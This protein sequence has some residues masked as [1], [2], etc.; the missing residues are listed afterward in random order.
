MVAWRDGDKV[1][2]LKCCFERIL[3]SF[4]SNSDVQALEPLELLGGVHIPSNAI[5]GHF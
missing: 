2:Y 4:S 1:Q 5:L 3:F